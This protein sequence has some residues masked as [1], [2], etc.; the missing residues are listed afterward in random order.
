MYKAQNYTKLKKL[1][2]SRVFLSYEVT[3]NSFFKNWLK[4]RTSKLPN[5]LRRFNIFH[6]KKKCLK[7]YQQGARISRG[8]NTAVHKLRRQDFEDF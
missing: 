1:C 7:F 3:T 5:G 4:N 8:L 6:Y 2:S